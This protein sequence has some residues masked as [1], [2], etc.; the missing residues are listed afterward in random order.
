[1]SSSSTTVTE[2]VVAF[3]EK[4][5]PFQF[6]PLQEIRS[7]ARTMMKITSLGELLRIAKA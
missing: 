3:L 5:P 4:I 7:L 6:L 1:M 2:S